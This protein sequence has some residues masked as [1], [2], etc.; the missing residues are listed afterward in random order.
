MELNKGAVKHLQEYIDA[1]IKD[2]GFD[3]ENLHERLLLLV[4]EVGELV[5]ACRHISGMNVD[6]DRKAM[7]EAGE[8][9]ADVINM[10]FAVAIKLRLD[11][12]KEFIDKNKKVD[13]RVYKRSENKVL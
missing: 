13:K 8:E 7:N 12:E 1:K 9:V 3:G 11:V 10:V 2:R 5:N 4:E 6:K